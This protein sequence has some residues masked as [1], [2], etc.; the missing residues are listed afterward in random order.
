MQCLPTEVEYDH[1]Q[2]QQRHRLLKPQQRPPGKQHQHQRTEA[3]P[4]G[5]ATV[6][7]VPHPRRHQRAEHTRQAKGTDGGGRPVQRR[8]RQWQRCR[9]PEHIE[10]GKQQQRQRS[11]L[12]QRSIPPQHAQHRAQQR[13]P[14]RRYRRHRNRRQ[15]PPQHPCQGCHQQR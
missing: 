13:R 8:C 7:P 6:H 10:A 4:M 12:A 9:C 2:Q 1:A 3:D 11:T 5:E 14:A 15:P